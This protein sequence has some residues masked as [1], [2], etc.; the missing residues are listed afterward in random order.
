MIRKNAI[1]RKVGPKKWCVFSRK[2]NPKT[3]MRRNLGCAGS[4]AGAKKRLRQVEFFKRH[5]GALLY[6]GALYVPAG[7]SE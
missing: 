1:I 6:R 2:K 5:G 7:A 4:L 3:G